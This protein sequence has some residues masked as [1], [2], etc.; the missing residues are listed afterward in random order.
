[1]RRTQT[2]VE[3]LMQSQEFQQRYPELLRRRQNEMK[4]GMQHNHSAMTQ[5][6]R[7]TSRMFNASTLSPHKSVSNL[8]QGRLSKQPSESESIADSYVMEQ[9][10]K[11]ISSQGS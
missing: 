5:P 1:M 7:D 11:P 6:V 3:K 4:E 8:T 9:R 2:E 10:K